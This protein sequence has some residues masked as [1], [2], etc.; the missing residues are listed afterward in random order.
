MSVHEITIRVFN[1][2]VNENKPF[3]IKEVNEEAINRGGIA[4]IDLV[5]PTKD[6]FADLHQQGLLI[7]HSTSSQGVLYLPSKQLLRL[8][9]YNPHYI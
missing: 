2:K 5:Y 1:E 7:I 9:K 8:I 3:S 6:Y 4:R